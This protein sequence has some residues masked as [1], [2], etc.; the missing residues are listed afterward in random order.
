MLETG[1]MFLSQG[2]QWVTS[3][4]DAENTSLEAFI[5]SEAKQHKGHLDLMI[6]KQY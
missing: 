2:C 1:S 3:L 4:M 6:I 5:V